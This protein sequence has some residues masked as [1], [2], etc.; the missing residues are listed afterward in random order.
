MAYGFA[1]VMHEIE[2]SLRKESAEIIVTN[3]FP[4]I[5]LS[6]KHKKTEVHTLY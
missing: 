6:F 5:F 1:S 3:F 4:K 2:S